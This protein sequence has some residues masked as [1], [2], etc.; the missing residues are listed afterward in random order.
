M[1]CRPGIVN[2]APDHPRGS[3]GMPP[4][5][6]T[7]VIGAGSVL[8]V[9]LSVVTAKGLAV[10]LGPGGLGA[11]GLMQSLVSMAAIAASMGVGTIAVTKVAGALE[12]SRHSW[13]RGA[14]AVGW[15]GG[16]VAALLLV[17][18]REPLAVA[19]FND[20]GMAGTIVILAPA[21]AA[22][23]ASAS[24]IALLTAHR[25]VSRIV[26]SNVGTYAV[27]ALAG[28]TLAVIFGTAGLAPAVL[29]TAIT[30]LVLTFT[31]RRRISMRLG[32]PASGQ[33][34]VAAATSLV[35][36]GIPVAAS[37]MVGLGAQLA[38]PI[39]VVHALSAEDVGQYRAA[40]AISL[41]Y[42]MFFVGTLVHDYLA[43]AA[44]TPDGVAL[45]EL[46]ERRM[47]LMAAIAI[48]VLLGLLAARHL[49]VTL[50]Y[51]TEFSPA[52]PVLEW[53]LI[54]DL[55]R[56]PGAVLAVTLLSRGR[57]RGYVILELLLGASLLIGTSI[58]LTALGLEGVG[59]AYFVASGF[60]FGVSW[61]LVSRTTPLVAGR[62]QLA[63][64]GT[65]VAAVGILVADIPRAVETAAIGGAAAS[66]VIVAWPRLWRLH[67]SGAL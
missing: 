35:R 16:L 21:A 43:R 44:A 51:T 46:I 31:F 59:V 29:A 13:E 23:S 20:A 28:V 67:R 26:Y 55:L 15:T 54:G 58:G 39:L 60:Y 6:A 4:L 7:M 63:F 52:I 41:G 38:V 53:I 17:T 37:Q 22:T 61:M 64:T 40:A 45:A 66:L 62:V 36:G 18:F 14:V 32:P 42:L 27:A 56:L 19:V 5:T 24:E 3:T 50:L 12:D 49:I 9:A 34:I 1:P 48:P 57:S 10:L 2:V 8:T 47:R 11:I 25:R 33:T 65:A 30:Q